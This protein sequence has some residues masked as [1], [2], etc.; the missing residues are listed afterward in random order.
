MAFKG[1][2]TYTSEET[3]NI[4]LGQTGFI[5]VPV[6]KKLIIEDEVPYIADQAYPASG[7]KV[8][9]SNVRG[10]VTQFPMIKVMQAGD[11]ACKTI[12]GDGFSLTGD[13]PTASTMATIDVAV[14]LGDAYFG[15]FDEVWTGSSAIIFAYIG[16]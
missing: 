16:I 11:I 2:R 10:K 3:S 7:S 5:V 8:R 14:A 13:A 12:S 15:S 6:S 1:I 4:L 9:A